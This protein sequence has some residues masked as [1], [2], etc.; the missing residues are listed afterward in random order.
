MADVVSSEKRSQMM[1]GIKGKD[2]KPEL[3][4]RK[5]LHGRGFR[6][7]IH[8]KD[9][10]GKPDIVLPK[11]KAVL[12]INGCFWHG[13]TCHLFKLPSSKIDFWKRKISRNQELDCVNADKLLSAGWRVGIIWEC[14]LKGKTKRTFEYIIDETVR[15][16]RSKEQTF[17]LRD[18]I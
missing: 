10:P 7:R 11:Y 16:I 2:T 8:Q 13:H 14:A 17:D 5:A 15:W 4:I 3:F 1:A 6:Y 12:F 18:N 9:L